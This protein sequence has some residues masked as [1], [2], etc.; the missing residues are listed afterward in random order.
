VFP[1]SRRSLAL[2][3]NRCAP[4]IWIVAVALTLFAPG[5]AV[6][7]HDVEIGV[8][9]ERLALTD[10]GDAERAVGEWRRM[11]VEVVRVHA[12]WS[13]IAPAGRRAPAKFAARDPDDPHYAWAALDHAVR[14][15][16]AARIR[17]ILTI[18]GPNPHWANQ[19]K[20]R[21]RHW[22]RYTWRPDPHAYA[23]FATAVARRYGRQVDR[24]TIWNEPNLYLLP[25]V[26]CKQRK[27]RRRCR[28]VAPH[29]YRRL[30][31]YGGRA[32]R[33]ADPGA[34]IGIGELASIGGPGRIA[35]IPFLRE[36]ACVTASYQPRRTGRCRHFRALRADALAYHPHSRRWPPDRPT[37]NPDN[38]RF[39]DLQRLI[40]TVDELTRRG[41]IR[42][43]RRRLTIR[44]TEF[45]YQT[46]PPDKARG[47]TPRVQA[48]YVQTAL[49]LAW[50]H[51]RIKTLI[52]YQWA[53]EA[54]HNRGPGY[55]RYAGWQSGLRFFDGRPKPAMRAFASPF[56]AVR[57]DTSVMFWGQAR[58]APGHTVDLQRRGRRR[59]VRVARVQ[60]SARGVWHR[61][62]ADVRPGRYRFVL[63]NPTPA[64]QRAQH[65]SHVLRLTGAAPRRAVI[66]PSG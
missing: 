52:H 25:L 29:T 30:V 4:G 65:P 24:Y 16:R 27:P 1:F 9:D 60:T 43:P 55:A 21:K 36:M 13:R 45:G 26:K 51:P 7:A 64:R 53:D 2:R 50:R 34:E 37:G 42:A 38:A 47:V 54:V 19:E 3:C 35:P 40:D 41:R 28:P 17:L 66:V 11:G 62:R 5:I 57:V 63:A 12:I 23:D 22:T 58:G 15:I 14:L 8:E 46:D 6:A 31:R 61:W 18:A 59:W 48:R 10:T 33:R 39:G 56:V 32:I 44:L 49:Y 20:H